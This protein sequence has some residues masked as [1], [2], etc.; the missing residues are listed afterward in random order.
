MR[1]HQFPLTIPSNGSPS[2]HCVV[3]C[4]LKMWVE[5]FTFAGGLPLRVHGGL[6]FLNLRDYNGIVQVTTLP[7]EFPVA[8][9][10]INDLRLEYVIAVEGVVRP[11]PSESVNKKMK[12]GSIGFAAE[13][14]Q[15]LNAVRSKL[16]FLVTTADGAKDF[17]K[18]EFR[19]RLKHQCSLDLLQKVLGII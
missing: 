5:G 4:P 17:V 8:H 6:T 2:L 10:T 15:V 7:D 9:S 19:L 12:T 11:R 1:L 3:N 18:E 16:P 13:F 14:V